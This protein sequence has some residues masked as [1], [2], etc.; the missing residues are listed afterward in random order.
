MR[1]LFRALSAVDAGPFRPDA[2][3]VGPARNEILFAGKARHPERVNDI[4]ALELKANVT[5]ARNMDFVRSLK[6]LIGCSA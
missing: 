5:P 1:M 2:E 3:L 6:P 4:D